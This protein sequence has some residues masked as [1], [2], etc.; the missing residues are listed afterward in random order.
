VTASGKLT[1]E[2]VAAGT[3]AFTQITVRFVTGTTAA[4]LALVDVK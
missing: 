2:A 1:D 4:G 3:E